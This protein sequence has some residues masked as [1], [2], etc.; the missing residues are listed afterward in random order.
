[1]SPRENPGIYL[2]IDFDWPRPFQKAYG[3]K[4]RKLHD[5][6][7]DK[8][9][10][11][12]VVAASGGVGAGPSSSWIFWLENYAALDRLLKNQED[13]VCKAYVDFFADMALV[14]EKIREKVLFL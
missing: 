4:A 8:G 11:K 10:I 13:E 3:D 12:E 2:M 14:S 5:V 9:W 7:Q 6:V 1:M